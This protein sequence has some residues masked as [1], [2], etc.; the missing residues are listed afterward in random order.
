MSE[1]EDTCS[2]RDAQAFLEQITSDPASYFSQSTSRTYRRRFSRPRLLRHTPPPP[3]STSTSQ[4]P[5][6]SLSHTL[7]FLFVSFL[8]F[9][10][11]RIVVIRLLQG[12]LN[13][14]PAKGTDPEDTGFRA[15]E[16]LQKST[17][18]AAEEPT[19]TND[20]NVVSPAGSVLHF[21]SCFLNA[22]CVLVTFFSSRFY[23]LD[24]VLI[25]SG[26][27]V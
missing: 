15:A 25:F 18:S 19:D 22:F 4:Y 20:A 24:V 26:R 7:F 14:S 2:Y 12:N 11:L 6:L 23:F 27:K 13:E 10:K 8:R 21:L 17:S 5:S 16:D 9:K 1:E 3:P